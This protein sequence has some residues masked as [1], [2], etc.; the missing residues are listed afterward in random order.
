MRS[1]R[2]HL[3]VLKDA[4]LASRRISLARKKYPA[5]KERDWAMLLSSYCCSCV[6]QTSVLVAIPS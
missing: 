3:M 2:R 6:S 5:G 1:Y 4:P